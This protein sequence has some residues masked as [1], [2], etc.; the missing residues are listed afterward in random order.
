MGL[1]IDA[2]TEATPAP[3]VL[4][5]TNDLTDRVVTE[6][7]AK[8][9]SMIVSY[10]PTPFS[11]IKK[12]VRED[13]ASRVILRSI[14]SGIAVYSPHTALDAVVGGVNDWLAAGVLGL[15]FNDA[16]LSS[17]SFAAAVRPVAPYKD[18]R[19]E[20][21]MLECLI[22]GLAV[23]FVLFSLKSCCAL[24]CSN[25]RSLA[26]ATAASSRSQSLCRLPR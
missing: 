17:P 21:A 5:L 15:P 23:S 9:A 2:T 20:R 22:W 11:G 12:L 3:L 26:P 25:W 1:L 19:S 8:R 24:A 14:T 4:F 6:A 18:V 13:R 10:H 7:I 16:T